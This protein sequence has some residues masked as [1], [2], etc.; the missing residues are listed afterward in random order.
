MSLIVFKVSPSCIHAPLPT[1][2]FWGVRVA[3]SENFPKSLESSVIIVLSKWISVWEI[4]TILLEPGHVSR[5]AE[6][7]QL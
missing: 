1:S 2:T 6:E 7:V 5:V 4:R 3:L